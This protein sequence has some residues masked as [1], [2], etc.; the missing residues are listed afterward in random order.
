MMIGEAFQFGGFL[1]VSACFCCFIGL[2]ADRLFIWLRQEEAK[3]P[4]R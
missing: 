2:Q 4:F 1:F 3:N